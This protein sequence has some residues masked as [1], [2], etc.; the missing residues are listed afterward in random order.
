MMATGTGQVTV[1][2]PTRYRYTARASPGPGLP[3]AVPLPP[4]PVT[5]TSL[6]CLRLRPG[7]HLLG[8]CMRGQPH[9][10]PPVA[11]EPGTPYQCR[12]DVVQR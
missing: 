11:A 1:Y 6:S 7:R 9:G 10:D 2:M 4:S 8:Q 3:L 12:S 5:G